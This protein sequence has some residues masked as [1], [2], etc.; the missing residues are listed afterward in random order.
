MMLGLS[1]EAFTQ[2][3][4]VI[5]LVALLAGAVVLAG[6]LAGRL[7]SIWNQLFLVMTIATSVTGF[8]FPFT[9]MLPS[10][11]VGALSLVAL[12]I[13]LAA[14][15][16]GWRGTYVASAVLAFYLNAFVAVAQGFDKLGPGQGSPGFAAAQGG[17][18]VVALVLG[19]LAFRRF[20]RG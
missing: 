12:A 19:T 18:L 4:V 3:H 1:I 14:L 11:Y 6:L 16:R 20:R 7:P 5:S 10:H 17:L 2:L 9:Q 8:L 13:A 15:A